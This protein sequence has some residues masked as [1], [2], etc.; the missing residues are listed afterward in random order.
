MFNKK[1]G[2]KLSL[3]ACII[4][5][6]EQKKLPLCLS[7]LRWVPEVIVVDDYSSDDTPNIC[8]S[9]K[10]VRY[11]THKFEGFG[12]QKNYVL[13]LAANDWVLNVDADEIVTPELQIE[14]K[15]VLTGNTPFSGFFVRRKNLWF[16]RY[17]TDSL[18]GALRL[19]RKSEGRFN[20][21]YVH[22]SVILDGKCGQLNGLLLHKPE[23][24]ETFKKHYQ[25]YALKYG[26]LAAKDYLQRGERIT[27]WNALWK[28]ILI[29]GLVFL[30]E[31]FIKRKFLRGKAGLF[32]SLCN[33]ICYHKAY[34]DL[35]NIQKNLKDG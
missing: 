22:E 5:R 24:F 23:S 13:N 4:T 34:L 27:I 30:R 10:N 9:F 33:S 11:S 25:I 26:K 20:Q 14:I 35:L 16:G 31:Y 32:V 28:I 17:Y 29:P 7:S 6:N 15:D 1:N 8:H 21:G 18:P 12:I 3:S 19:F 2:P